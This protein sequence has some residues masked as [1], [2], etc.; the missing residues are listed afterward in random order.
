MYQY[1]ERLRIKV[2]IKGTC[3][4]TPPP[5][6]SSFCIDHALTTYTESK[7]SAKFCHT[8]LEEYRICHEDIR[9]KNGV[10]P[11]MPSAVPNRVKAGLG[12]HSSGFRA[13]CS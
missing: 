12:I 6:Y 11:Q 8:V 10:G 7:F 5:L 2:C 3:H 1:L 13:I 9:L 4:C